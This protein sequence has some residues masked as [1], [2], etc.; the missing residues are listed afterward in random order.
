MVKLMD[1]ISVYGIIK[2]VS[3]NI[4]QDGFDQLENAIYL[5]KTNPESRRIIINLWNPYTNHNTLFLVAYV[6]IILC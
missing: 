6:S 1:L 2:V 5:I 4:K 3:I